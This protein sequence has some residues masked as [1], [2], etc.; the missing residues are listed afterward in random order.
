[1]A[2]CQLVRDAYASRTSYLIGRVGDILYTPVFNIYSQKA[3]HLR[4]NCM[5]NYKGI[6]IYLF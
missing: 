3:G 5:S 4:W 6:N 1:M 2:A